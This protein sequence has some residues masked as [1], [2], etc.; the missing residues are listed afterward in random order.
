MRLLKYFSN[1]SVKKNE[2]HAYLFEIKHFN[3][4]KNNIISTSRVSYCSNFVNISIKSVR[5][6]IRHAGTE[7]KKL[8][9]R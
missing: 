2:M 3:F 1:F 6:L 4:T 7:L 5:G 9:N 8:S